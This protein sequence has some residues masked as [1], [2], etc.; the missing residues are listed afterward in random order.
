MQSEDGEEGC[1]EKLVGDGFNPLSGDL[2]GEDANRWQEEEEAR[3]QVAK[4]IE[5]VAVVMKK[6]AE[7]K[8]AAGKAKD[9]VCYGGP[10]ENLTLFQCVWINAEIR[11]CIVSFVLDG[12]GI[13][14]CS[15]DV[16]LPTVKVVK[17]KNGAT[18]LEITAETSAD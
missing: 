5:Q 3:L 12:K 13:S 14:K 10:N 7:E 2:Y 8:A 18:V 9:E 15:V 17:A 4:A 16:F 1:A 6:T 11:D